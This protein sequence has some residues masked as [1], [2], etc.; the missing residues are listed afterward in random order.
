[1]VYT[2]TTPPPGDGVPPH[3]EIVHVPALKVAYFEPDTALLELLCG[4]AHQLVFY[5]R[6]AIRAFHKASPRLPETTARVW[7]V[8]AKTLACARALWPDF[9]GLWC[10]PPPDRQRYEGLLE[11][12]CEQSW[13]PPWTVAL[14]L[15]GALRPL[16]EQSRAR[17]V[18]TTR[19]IERSL[20]ETVANRSALAW[21]AAPQ[22]WRGID[23]L[24]LASPR[25]ASLCLPRMPVSH[26]VALAALGPSTSAEAMRHIDA[27]IFMP[28]VPSLEALWRALT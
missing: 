13:H 23:W 16:G 20:Y 12:F 25:A 9:S 5:S 18:M 7:C 14:G 28:E 19:V 10:S 6:H 3:L 22:R 2:G 17:G 8:G 11:A 24:V 26:R 27:A 15:Q 21:Y 4:E 1:M